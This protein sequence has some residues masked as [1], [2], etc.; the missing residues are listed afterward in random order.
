MVISD[1]EMVTK[2]KKKQNAE[3]MKSNRIS[4]YDKN[5][6]DFEFQYWEQCRHLSEKELVAL[7]SHD[8]FSLSLEAAKALLLIGGS[9]VIKLAQADSYNNSYKRRA[10]AAFIL[11]QIRLNTKEEKNSLKILYDLALN[12]QSAI[13]RSYAV[14]SF[15]Q[16]YK[17]IKN[18]NLDSLLALAEKTIL[19]KSFKVRANTA[20]ALSMFD[21]E[22]SIPLLIKLLKD[23][24]SEVKN[25]AAFAVNVNGYDTPE[26]RNCFVLLLKENNFDVRYEA[27]TGLAKRLNKSV[28][29]LI[30]QELSEDK[31]DDRMI[32]LI[33]YLRDDSLL[34]VLYQIK[35]KFGS[36]KKL[37]MC[38]ENLEKLKVKTK[39]IQ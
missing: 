1:S 11:G 15:G 28:A 29:Q 38:I 12:D 14:L 39:F 31:I 21:Y 34:P 16:R 4:K 6:E 8:N 2:A 36:S 17:G 23:T 37:N 24:H 5:Q 9:K 27:I 7:L 13:V 18:K 33:S 19:D 3:V 20:I 22:V 32:E 30:I 10:L 35:D 25:W 26:I